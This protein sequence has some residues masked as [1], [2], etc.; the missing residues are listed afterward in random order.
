MTRTDSYLNQGQRQQMVDSL[1]SRGI[2]DEAVLEAMLRVPRHLFVDPTFAGMAYDDRPLPIDCGQTISHPSTVAMQ[3]Q[4]LCLR[5]RMKVLEIGTGSGYQSAV[6]CAMEAS[7]F[8]IERHKP[9]YDKT[10]RLLA[11]LGYRAC[12]FH[13]DGY[14]GLAGKYDRIIVTCGATSLP[15]K[16]MEQLKTGGI[17]VIPV[18]EQRQRML[19]ITKR[20]ESEDEWTQEEFGLYQFVP[21]KTGK[22]RRT[23]Q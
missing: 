14:Q 3:T 20:G 12:C 17:M 5:P 2:N 15:V 16:L 1:R 10:S 9:L 22:A 19:R 21:M 23:L 18:G 13:G 7:V 6:L 4:L 11:E 8:T